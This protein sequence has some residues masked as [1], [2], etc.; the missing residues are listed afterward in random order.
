M[1]TYPG[2]VQAKVVR[3]AVRAKTALP[4]IVS[5]QGKDLSLNVNVADLSVAG[6]MLDAP[7]PLG[8][9]GEAVNLALEVEFEGNK[10]KLELRA[11][12][13]YANKSDGAGSYSIGIE[14]TDITQNDKLVLHYVAQAYAINDGNIVVP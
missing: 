4:G 12:I 5:A 10:I 7:A 2:S 8:N 3:K 6:A 1:L 9:P 11:Q 14:F 13:R